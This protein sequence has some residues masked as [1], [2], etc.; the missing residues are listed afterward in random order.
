M[1]WIYR[2]QS[3]SKKSYVGQTVRKSVKDR[4]RAH[5][6]RAVS[7]SGACRA[8][9]AAIRK[10]GW[11]NM[12]KSVL[13]KVDDHGDL[14]AKERGWIA[15]LDTFENGYNLTKGG[16]ENPMRNKETREQLKRTLATPKARAR[17]SAISKA[18]HADAEKHADWLEKHTA[19]HRMPEVRAKISAA[20]RIAWSRQGAREQRGKSI[21]DALNAPSM[22][23]TKQERD[24]KM[25][26]TKAAQYEAKLASLPPEEANRRRK[27]AEKTARNRAKRKVLMQSEPDRST[28]PPATARGAIM[29]FPMAPSDDE[30]YASD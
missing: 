19:A 13:E 9:K 11:E 8:L 3:P 16:D 25:S 23:S 7:N 27:A 1:G 14:D 6:N 22:K 15:K 29:S 12:T 21:R 20:N 5:K 17:M 24:A 18:Y 10:Y 30:D 26:A 2:I 4:W 28:P